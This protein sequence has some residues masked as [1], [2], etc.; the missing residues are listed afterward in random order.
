MPRIDVHR[1]NINFNFGREF[2]EIEAADAVH[3]EAHAGLEFSRN[4]FRVLPDVQCKLCGTKHEARRFRSQLLA[5]FEIRLQFA[6]FL[7][8]WI[9]RTRNIGATNT[10]LALDGYA[11]A[12]L[13]K[14][15]VGSSG[16]TQAKRALA[17]LQVGHAHP[18]KEHA[19]K[20]LWRKR[21]GNSN[22]GTENSGIAQPGPER[23]ALT[24]SFDFC[25]AEWNGIFSNLQMPL[26]TLDFSRRKIGK[27]VAGIARQKV[28]DVVFAWIHPGHE[29]RP[30]HR[31]N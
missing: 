4:P 17:A 21:D 3:R 28:V 25:F 6:A 8:Q 29:R 15:V 27:I 22:H 9:I 7:D 18:G 26:R 1:R 10:V 14:L 13:T 2:L 16:G 31:G 20:L 5:D 30:R 23:R 24:H 12:T 11:N 19:L